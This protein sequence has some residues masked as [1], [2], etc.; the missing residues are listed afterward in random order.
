MKKS[1]DKFSRPWYNRVNI[2]NKKEAS[3]LKDD[4]CMTKASVFDVAKYILDKQ[5]SISSW[6]LQKLCFYAQA[7]NL[8]WTEKPIFAEDFQAWTN[9]PVCPELFRE[10]KGLFSIG[11]NHCEKGDVLNL[12]ASH[13]ETI[14]V[15]LE[16]YG[17]KDP[18]WLREQSHSEAPWQDARGDLP[19]NTRCSAIIT[20][21]KM[22]V[23]YG[24]L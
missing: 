19:E 12:E 11:L 7:W 10:F 6:K 4:N 24:G 14:D 20:K 3:F 5:G 23:F 22:G 13:T 1:F 2:W 18:Y 15:V 17:D 21:E 9:G 16:N 8:A